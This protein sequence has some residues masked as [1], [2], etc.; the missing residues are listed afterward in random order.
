MSRGCDIKPNK[1]PLLSISFSTFRRGAE[2]NPDQKAAAT[3]LGKE[4]ISGSQEDRQ[5]AEA[6]AE[7]N[8]GKRASLETG[9]ISSW[10]E[11]KAG[12]IV[13][14]E[15]CDHSLDWTMNTDYL[16][17][18]AK[19]PRIRYVNFSLV[20]PAMRSDLPGSIKMT[21]VPVYVS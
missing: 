13:D 21:S 6:M 5:A 11:G 4:A 10:K 9:I 3:V 17:C 2:L 14:H 1:M 19:E 20:G 15:T 7:G 8:H 18:R 12:P 16:S